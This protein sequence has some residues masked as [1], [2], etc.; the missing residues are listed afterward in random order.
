[1]PIMQVYYAAEALEA[2]TKADLARRL[3]E[4]L[5]RMEGGANTREGRAFAWVM[6][7]QLA[8]D[9]WWVGGSAAEGSNPP[10]GRFLVAVTIP[11]GYM[12][13]AQKND[14]HGWVAE[15]ILASTGVPRTPECGAGILVVIH[16]VT[17]GNWS[18]AGSPL[19]LEG[20]ANSV[21]LSR[22]SERFAWSRRYFEAKARWLAGAGFPDDMGGVLPSQTKARQIAQN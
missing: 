12:N 9:D 14:V 1:M 10:P 19:S 22:Q 7:S 5:I 13:K 15:S 8:H 17:E 11:E 20:I 6:F 3:T 4:V 18:A 21:G 2:P 16:E